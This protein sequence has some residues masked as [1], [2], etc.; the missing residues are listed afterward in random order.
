MKKT[1]YLDNAGAT[2]IDPKVKRVILAYLEK[3]GNVSSVHTAGREAKEIIDAARKTVA[4]IINARPEEVV[5]TSSGTESANLAVLGVARANKE[6]GKHII[7]TQTEH[8]AVL[9]ACEYL[10]KNEGFKVEYLEVE[11]SGI[12][13][14]LTLKNVLRKETVLVSVMYA[15][16]EIGTIQP[17]QEISKI[18]RRFEKE[19]QIRVI[20][21]TDA[22][23]AA[24]ALNLDVQKLGVDSMTLNGSKIYGPK[25]TG[26]LFVRQGIKLMPVILGGGQERG[27]RDGTEKPALIAGFAEALKIVDQNKE[28]ESKRQ[29]KLRDRLISEILK[30]IPDSRLNG[31]AKLRLP[32]NINISFKDVDGEMLMLFLDRKGICISTGSACSSQEIGPSRVMKAIKNP[33]GWGNIRISLGLKTTRK[34]L[35]WTLE[36]IKKEVENLRK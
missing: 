24:G 22:C 14:P 3:F 30:S 35:E 17:I 13:N 9:K 10:E 8:P 23:Q 19:N 6:K 25:G 12:I 4:S 33:N 15:N 7:T 29:T 21:H 5:F 36:L 2:P 27:L 28:K 16:N 20:F 31:D 34:E 18:I 11:D 26:C 1:I 32:N